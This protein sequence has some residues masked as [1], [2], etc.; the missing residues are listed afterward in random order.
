LHVA[1]RQYLG[2]FGGDACILGSLNP[3]D[4]IAVPNYDANKMRVKGYDL[5]FLLSPEE[6]KLVKSNTPFPADSKAAKMLA[7][8]IAG[9]QPPVTHVVNIGGHRGTLIDI[10]KT[11]ADAVAEVEVEAAVTHAQPVAPIEEVVP[12]ND[13]P[14][15]IAVVLDAA[16]LDPTQL[17]QTTSPLTEGLAVEE[18]EEPVEQAP[19]VEEKPAPKA[20]AKAAP[21]ADSPR[22]KIAA[23]LASEPMSAELAVKVNAI[24]RA[25][26]K[27]W[28]K[29]GVD[30]VTEQKIKDLL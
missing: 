1:R 6:F 9:K 16:P 30:A 28:D 7:L 12:H 8:I 10:T 17:A 21:A 20:K 13:G 23:L 15:N 19:V 18:K 27:G 4:V 22:A 11:E 5:H 24:K 29:L 2:S 3:E 25:A 14:S 26:K